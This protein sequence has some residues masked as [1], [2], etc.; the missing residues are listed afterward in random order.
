LEQT[1][2]T[3]LLSEGGGQI[4]PGGKGVISGEKQ[5]VGEKRRTASVR[6]NEEKPQ[7]DELQGRA[8]KAWFVL[9]GTCKSMMGEGRWGGTY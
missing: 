2:L 8:K 7:R 1:H 4:C 3:R 9:H 5:S 6:R